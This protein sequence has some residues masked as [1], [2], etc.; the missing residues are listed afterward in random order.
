MLKRYFIGGIMKN[1]KATLL[2]VFLM[3]LATTAV[4]IATEASFSKKNIENDT[5]S[6]LFDAEVTFYILTGEGCG[7]D[8]IPDVSIQAFGGEGSV[9]GVTDEDGMCVLTL[10]ILGEYEVLI[11]KD[12]YHIID[13]EFNVLDDQTFTFHLEKKDISSENTLLI[14]HKFIRNILER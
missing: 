10:V 3:V 2:V 14:F 4:G 7:C 6:M 12:E 1:I 11:E 9:S 13:F 8:P 5:Q